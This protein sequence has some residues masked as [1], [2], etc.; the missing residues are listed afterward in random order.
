M[1]GLSA[2]YSTADAGLKLVWGYILA[3]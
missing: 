3:T 2:H 1:L